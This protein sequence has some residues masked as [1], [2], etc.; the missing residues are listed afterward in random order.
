MP[1]R[2]ILTPSISVVLCNQALINLSNIAYSAALPLF[3]YA[4]VAEGGIG[5]SKRGE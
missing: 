4:T 2:H 5:F 1:F 3:C